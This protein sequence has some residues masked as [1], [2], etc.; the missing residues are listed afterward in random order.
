MWCRVDAGGNMEKARNIGVKAFADYFMALAG[1]FTKSGNH[2]SSFT[3]AA[4]MVLKNIR[5]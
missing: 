2:D 5:G 3:K 4:M 1:C